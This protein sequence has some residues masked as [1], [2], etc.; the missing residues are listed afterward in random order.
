MERINKSVAVSQNGCWIWTK[1]I[2]KHGYA[3]TSVGSKA[4]LLAHR[5]AYEA[6]VGPIPTG[7]QLDH[8]CRTRRCVNPKHLEPV[9]LI[10]NVLRGE[11]PSAINARKTHCPKGHPYNE[12]NTYTLNGCRYCRKC[13]VVAVSKYQRRMKAKAAP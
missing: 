4:G 12:A 11:G 7:L 10:E 13:N 8:L 1:R 5:V 2:D 3:R 6:A 9:T